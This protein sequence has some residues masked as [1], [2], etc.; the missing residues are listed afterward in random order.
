VRGITPQSSPSISIDEI[1]TRP[2]RKIKYEYDFGDGWTDTIKFE[3]R[4]GG[5]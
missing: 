1:F 4:R 3:N 2:N 5:G